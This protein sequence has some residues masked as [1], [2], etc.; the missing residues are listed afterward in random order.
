MKKYT[1]LL[2]YILNYSIVYGQFIDGYGIN[3]GAGLSNQHW[4]YS[5]EIISDLSYWNDYKVG[6]ISQVYI[7]KKLIRFLSVKPALG[8]IQKGFI[9]NIEIAN[10]I[11]EIYT[12]SGKV[13]LHD[14]SFDLSF[15]IIPFEKINKP[16]L[17]LGFR[18]DYLVGHRSAMDEYIVMN[19]QLF[20]YIFDNYNKITFGGI[21][22]AGISFDEKIYLNLEYNPAFTKNFSSTFTD[23]H[24]SDSFSIY[25]QYISFTLGFN[26]GQLMKKKNRGE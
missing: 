2:L 4:N 16:Y 21:L 23:F 14:I 6:V 3:I 12:L 18:T 24:N 17:I 26:I 11:G 19:F 25:D 15:R 20:K 13:L 7:E 22:G 10:E 9:S 1:F 5:S 8:Y